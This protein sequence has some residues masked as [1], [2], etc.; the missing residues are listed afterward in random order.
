MN[1]QRLI[2]KTRK[3]GINKCALVAIIR[4][5]LAKVIAAVLYKR[6][7]CITILQ[8]T[9]NTGSLVLVPCTA[10]TKD[11]RV[12]IPDYL[13]TSIGFSTTWRIEDDSLLMIFFFIWNK[14]NKSVFVS[15]SF[16]CEIV[17]NPE[18]FEIIRN[19]EYSHTAKSMNSF[20][21]WYL[22]LKDVV[23]CSGPFSKLISRFFL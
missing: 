8:D 20:F 6:Q 2:E 1:A 14:N 13:T 19:F 11:I 10:V 18:L 23:S 16:S 12:S 22:T 7:L 21:I 17:H 9:C 4:S 3:S 5:I 15:L